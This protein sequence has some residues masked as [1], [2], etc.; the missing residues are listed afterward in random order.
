MD[1][2]RVLYYCYY[3]YHYYYY[4]YYYYHYYYLRHELRVHVISDPVGGG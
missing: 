4:H 3:Y 2:W 1:L